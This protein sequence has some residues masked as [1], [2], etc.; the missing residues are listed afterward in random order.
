MEV[1]VMATYK[2]IQTYVRTEYGFVPKS[3]WIAHCKEICGLPLRKSRRGDKQRVY[4]CPIDKREKIME[5]FKYF[6][7][8]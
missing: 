7:I 5:T 6:K 4:P 3:C 1:I 8:I 2:Q